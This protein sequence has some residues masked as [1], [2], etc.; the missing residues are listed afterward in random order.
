M[1]EEQEREID[2]EID[3]YRDKRAV[4]EAMSDQRNLPKDWINP[5][6]Y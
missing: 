2:R 5:H 3:T 4:E 6:K 1:T